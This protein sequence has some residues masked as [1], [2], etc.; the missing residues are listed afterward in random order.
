MSKRTT[1]DTSMEYLR[2]LIVR[3]GYSL[4]AMGGLLEGRGGL[5]VHVGSMKADSRLR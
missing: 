3:E 2:R 5:M 4:L 1:E